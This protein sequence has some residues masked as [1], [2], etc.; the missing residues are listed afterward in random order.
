MGN[1]VNN[2]DKWELA[3]AA[4]LSAVFGVKNPSTPGTGGTGSGRAFARCQLFSISLKCDRPRGCG[5]DDV[6]GLW[7]AVRGAAC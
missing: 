4:G 7:E 5:R 6:P 2:E 1:Q 3:R